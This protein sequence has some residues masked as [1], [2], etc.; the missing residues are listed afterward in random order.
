MGSTLL[1]SFQEL[2]AL[3][4]GIMA[5][6]HEGAVTVLCCA[7][8]KPKLYIYNDKKKHNILISN[9]NPKNYIL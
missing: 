5:E 1:S 4:F 9:S 6:E 8:F 7:Y 3:I 2:N